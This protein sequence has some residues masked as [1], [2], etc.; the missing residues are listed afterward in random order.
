MFKYD[1]Q[2]NNGGVELTVEDKEAFVFMR[3]SLKL[4]NRHYTVSLPRKHSDVTLPNNRQVALRRIT[5]LQ[6]R[7]LKDSDFYEL[8]DAKMKDNVINDHAC[9]ILDDYLQP[10]QKKWYLSHHTTG[11]K[12]RIVFDCGASFKR[13]SL[14]DKLLQGPDL[15]GNSLGV[16]TR[17]RE[18][19][20]PSLLI[21]VPCFIRLN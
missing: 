9:K 4:N 8:Y 15:T 14:N 17:F 13:T 21:Y 12:F 3:S 6:K 2:T 20:M 16:L 5:Y 7:F 1:F 19:A 10:G 11:N 18:G